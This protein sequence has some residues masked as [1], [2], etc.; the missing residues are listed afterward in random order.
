MHTYDV[1]HYGTIVSLIHI[2]KPI[3]KYHKLKYRVNKR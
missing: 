2:V 3:N 1:N